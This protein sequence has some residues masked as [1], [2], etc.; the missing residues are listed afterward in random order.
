MI[1][2]YFMHCIYRQLLVKECKMQ[3]IDQYKRLDLADST[4]Y[5]YGFNSARS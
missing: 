3:L 4:T 2:N 5:D 1:G